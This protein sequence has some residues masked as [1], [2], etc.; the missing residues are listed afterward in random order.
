M[1][2]DKECRNRL[3]SYN[4]P[5]K[6][7]EI[8]DAGSV[9]IWE[10]ETGRVYEDDKYVLE[11][12]KKVEKV[13]GKK[14]YLVIKVNEEEIGIYYI[15]CS[16]SYCSDYWQNELSEN[17]LKNNIFQ[18]IGP[19]YFP[20]EHRYS[21]KILICGTAFDNNSLCIVSSSAAL[22]QNRQRQIITKH[23]G[24]KRNR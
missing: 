12:I 9:P 17:Y 21:P 6:A 20:R 22:S 15:F 5:K 7:V 10:T 16:A 14:T 23:K 3:S 2:I 24:G 4:L 8:L 18:F 11:K 1:K 19:A 13:Y